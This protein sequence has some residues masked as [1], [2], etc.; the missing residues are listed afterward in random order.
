MG[1]GED[2][3]V[4]APLQRAGG[5]VGVADAE[6]AAAPGV[7]HPGLGIT[8][9]GN[10]LSRQPARGMQADFVEHAAEM[11]EAANF[12]VRTAETGNGW[13]MSRRL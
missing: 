10:I 4:I 2:F 6:E 7:E 8:E 12:R 3:F 11:D 13:H 5:E 1:P 9:V